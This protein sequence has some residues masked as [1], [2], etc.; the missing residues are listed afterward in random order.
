MLDVAA[1]VARH[2]GRPVYLDSNIFIYVLGRNPEYLNTCVDLLQ[3]CANQDI[4]GITGDATLTELLTKPMKENDAHAVA[5][6]R[7]MLLTDG[8]IDVLGHPRICFEQA[9]ALRARHRL[10]MVDALHL[11]TAIHAGAACFISNDFQFPQLSE[12]ECVRL[13]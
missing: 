13:D 6:V 12:I 9:A 2:H 7:K 1:L 5:A 10:K 4:V 11:A 8:A 3:A